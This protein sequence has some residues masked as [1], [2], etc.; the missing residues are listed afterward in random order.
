MTIVT[1]MPQGR[2]PSMTISIGL[3][4]TS[5][6]LS[7]PKVLWEATANNNA[8]FAYGILF[9]ELMQAYVGVKFDPH[10]RRRPVEEDQKL[11]FINSNKVLLTATSNM[12]G[13]EIPAP[14]SLAS[15]RNHA[16]SG[17]VF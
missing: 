15:L 17:L 13:I 3:A 5:V 14:Q 2:S 16:A 10:N 12:L 8:H 11:D 6:E 9:V 7:D 1:G 4:S